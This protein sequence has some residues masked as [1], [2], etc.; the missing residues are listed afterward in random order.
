M[1]DERAQEEM[2]STRQLESIGQLAA[3]IAHD[4][5]NL[6]TVINGCAELALEDPTLDPATRD[7][8]EDIAGAG[9]RAAEITRQFVAFGRRQMLLPG[10]IDLSALAAGVAGTIRQ[11]IGDTVKLTLTSDAE[12]V[13][14]IADPRQLERVLINLAANAAE[15]MPE[16]GTLTISTAA[17]NGSAVLTVSD[18]GRGIDPAVRAHLFEP[19]VTTKDRA[20][21]SGLGLAVVYGIVKQSG[22]SIDVDTEPG[23]TTF[24]IHFQSAEL[25]T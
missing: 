7:L 8:L 1:S 2:L 19:Y 11:Q 16:G 24:R 15:A 10:I 6:L 3:G 9:R 12:P 23:R 5:N 14:I 18:T 25:T 4:F 21:G 17:Q 13:W 22:G 20:R